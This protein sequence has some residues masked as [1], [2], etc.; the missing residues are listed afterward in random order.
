MRS[1]LVASIAFA[2]LLAPGLAAQVHQ[3]HPF[4]KTDD[5]IV[6][7]SFGGI[8]L[9]CHDAN[10]D[11]DYQDA[12]EVSVFF[13]PAVALDPT[14][15][16]PYGSASLGN[17]NGLTLDMQGWIYVSD[18]GTTRK[19]FRLKDLDGDGDANDAGESTIFFSEANAAGLTSFSLWCPVA[20]AN[21]VLH[22]SAAG[23]GS[24]ATGTDRVFRLVDLNGDGDANDAGEHAVVFDRETSLLAG[25]PSIDSPA[26][27][28]TLPDGSLYLTNGFIS[29]QG[30][31]RLRDLDLD[32]DFN[33]AGEVTSIYSGANGNP[34][35]KFVW[36]ARFAQNGRLYVYSQTDKRVLCAIDANRDGLYDGA[37]E[38]FV[39]ASSGDGGFVLSS[40]FNFDVR[41]DGAI[42]VG[43]TGGS[44]NNKIVAYRDG[45]GDGVASGPGEQS[46]IVAFSTTAFASAKPRSLLFL[47]APTAVVGAGCMSSAGSPLALSIPPTA[48]LSKL[49]NAAFQMTISSGPASAPA[50]LFYSDAVSPIPLATLAPG[51]AE[52]TCLLQTDILSSEFNAIAVPALDGSGSVTFALPIPPSPHLGGKTF[53]VQ[54][55]VLD[56][57]GPFPL[58]LSNAVAIPML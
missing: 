8:V 37:S 29:N 13:D 5:L 16:L 3:I 27:I 49:G 7:D 41:G 40:A 4:Q 56:G 12:G 52:P 43:D 36:C 15:G 35:P 30:L 39:F 1:T 19:I 21:G 11:G 34:P 18:P 22:V 47:P 48:G 20:D 26:W 44:G 42:C 57:A 33:D 28:A 45:D 23:Q 9:R 14:T 51:A 10:G 54:A 38:A 24:G 17:P 58:V 2:A 6:G 25:N 31:W 46:V 32:G 53:V 55:L 50:G